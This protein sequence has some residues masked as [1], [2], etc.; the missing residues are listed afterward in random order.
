[1][2][3]AA[4]PVSDADH[5]ELRHVLRRS[6]QLGALQALLVA[7]FSFASRYLD[8]GAELA[9]TGLIVVVGVAA[10]IALP[11]LWTRARTVEG[12]AGAAGIGLG[13]TAVFLVIDV[14]ALQ[15][16]G[17]YTNRWLEIGG[18]SNWWY[19][20]V[21]WMA[22][23]Y[24][25][26]LGAWVLAN[27]AAKSGESNPTVLVV[28]TLVLAAAVMAGATLIHFPG[29]AFGLGT[30]SVSV[31]PALALMVIVSRLGAPRQ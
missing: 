7:A 31:L 12:V 27:Q 26:W 14:V 9:V 10:V 13:A 29:A 23:T 25:S 3:S 15:P 20:P 24:L 18:G 4:H 17:M 30:F 19:H 6:A 2:T 5:T 11:G 1:M 21:W 8:G 16:A 22:G 28:G